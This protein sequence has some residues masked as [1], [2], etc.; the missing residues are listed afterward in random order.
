MRDPGFLEFKLP[1]GVAPGSYRVFAALARQATTDAP[2][3]AVG[4]VLAV[5]S[6]EITIAR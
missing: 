2:G 6:R 1:A 5:D 3:V 4:A